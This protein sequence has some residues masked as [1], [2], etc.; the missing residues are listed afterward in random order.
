[1]RAAARVACA[2]AFI[3]ALPQGYDTL[4]GERGAK[5][6]DDRGDTLDER[7]LSAIGAQLDAVR[8]TLAAHGI[9]TGSPLAQRLFS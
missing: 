5:L 2:D 4:L 8:Q 9:E 3:D 6:V 7:A 1:V